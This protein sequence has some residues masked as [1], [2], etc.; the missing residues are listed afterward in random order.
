MIEEEL[1]RQLFFFV[2]QCFLIVISTDRRKWR[3]LQIP[4]L[5]AA[6]LGMT[7]MGICG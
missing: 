4:R 5:L 2:R 6:S 3:N 7:I 1:F